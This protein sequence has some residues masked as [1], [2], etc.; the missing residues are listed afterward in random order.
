M[1]YDVFFSA[2]F[3]WCKFHFLKNSYFYLDTDEKQYLQISELLLL[4]FN[5]K[6][7]KVVRFESLLLVIAHAL[8][9]FQML[10]DKRFHDQS[11]EAIG[12]HLRENYK[13]MKFEYV[14][15]CAA[16][17]ELAGVVA[18]TVACQS[19]RECFGKVL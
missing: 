7:Y 19:I 15:V 17:Q 8:A 14:D 5:Q 3:F 2:R 16:Y 9:R 18:L 1:F 4:H 11:I 6:D 13:N 10:I 12:F